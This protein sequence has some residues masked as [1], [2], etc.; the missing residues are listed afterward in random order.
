MLHGVSARKKHYHGHVTWPCPHP[1]AAELEING[2]HSEFHTCT[3]GNEKL[4]N[5]LAWP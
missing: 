3:G 5:Y 1:A 4:K 2:A